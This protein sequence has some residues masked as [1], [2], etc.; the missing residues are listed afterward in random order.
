MN[1]PD[2]LLLTGA[3]KLEVDTRLR[4]SGFQFLSYNF[5]RENLSIDLSEV[6]RTKGNYYIS[7]DAYQKQIE[8]QLPGN[9]ALLQVDQDTLF[10][11]FKK[12]ISK[13]VKV[14]PNLTIDLAQ[15]HLLEGPLIVNP[16][17]I[18]IRGP[19]NEIE[20]ID[21][22]LTASSTFTNVSEDFNATVALLKPAEFENTIYDID[23][24][25][26]SAEVF[27]FSEQLIEVP[28][29]VI[30]IPEG[31]EI[32]TFPNTAPILCKA[33]LDQLKNLRPQEF[34]LVADFSADRRE[35]QQMDLKLMNKPDGVYDAQLMIKKVEFILIRR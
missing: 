13:E 18:M 10:V 26:I 31:S 6:K 34:E 35:N 20:L 9:M 29:T 22:I 14:R 2:S 3:S 15:N 12:M 11:Y 8:N 27:R 4:A 7:R 24:V 33:R 17:S 23:Q 30:N 5:G 28:V 1:A 21:E 19:K 25:Q 32:K 16:P